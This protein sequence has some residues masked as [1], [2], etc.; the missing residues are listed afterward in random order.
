[1]A[2]HFQCPHVFAECA[3]TLLAVA[4]FTGWSN[5]CWPISS[6]ASEGNQMIRCY[7]SFR[8]GDVAIDTPPSK[9]SESR[10]SLFHRASA[11]SA[12]EFRSSR[13]YILSR[14]ALGLLWIVC[15]P[16][17][18]S[19]GGLLCFGCAFTHVVG[20]AHP[21]NNCLAMPLPISFGCFISLG[22]VIP[23]PLRSVISLKFFGLIARRQPK[24]LFCI[25]FLTMGCV[26]P[27]PPN[28]RLHSCLI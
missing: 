17:L 18:V 3:A 8:Q 7:R 9:E 21:L 15:S 23:L 4:R 1:M 16:S 14:I 26:I 22:A 19:L 25:D 20:S 11:F 5:I 6:A 27:S 24:A 13:N 2:K 28:D 10:I 12:M